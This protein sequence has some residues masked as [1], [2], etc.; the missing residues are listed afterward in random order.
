MGPGEVTAIGCDGPGPEHAA[1]QMGREKGGFWVWF[2]ATVFAGVI[3]LMGRWTVVGADR[4]PVSGPALIVSN[5]VSYLDPM[6]AGVFVYRTGRVPRFLAKHSLWGIPVV[7][8]MMA[9]TGQIPV[10]RDSVDAGRSMR[11]GVVALRQGKVV[12]IYPEGTITRDP[13]GWPM[14]SLPGVARLAL[15]VNVP[16]LPMVHWGTREVYDHYRKSFRPLPRKQIIVRCGDPI[17]LST[18]RSRP[19]NAVL[20]REVT[21]HLMGVVRELL[22]QVRDEPVPPTFDRGE[23]SRHD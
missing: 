10:Y 16:V 23:S 15:A 20:L 21:D 3:H 12:V 18:F 2:T 14:R 7:R 13:A 11:D 1:P 6:F 4:I 5:H 9:A 8:R 22:A 17:D 19:V